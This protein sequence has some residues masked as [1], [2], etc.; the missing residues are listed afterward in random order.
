MSEEQAV[1]L[2]IGN[3]GIATI[4]LN[5]P[6]AFNS[7]NQALL[8]GLLTALL[9]AEG[10]ASVRVVIV[11]GSG[12]AFCGGGDLKAM[13][14]DIDRIESA[15]GFFID[16]ANAAV[17]AMRRL[18][19]PVICSVHG[20]AAGGGFALAAA[21]DFIVAAESA[22]FVIAYSKIAVSPDAGLSYFLTE[23]LG[24]WRAIDALLLRSHLTAA[25]LREAGMVTRVV[26][27][28]QLEAATRQLAQQI[29]QLPPTMANSV[30][31]LVNER[32]DR[33]LGQQM[34]SERQGFIR[35]TGS[36]E[37]AQRVDAFLQK[38]N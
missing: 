27:D 21:G 8:S 32:A 24:P 30:K 29:A 9:K 19:V 10:D 34:S 36:R 7:M 28:D 22:R 11:R 26:A 3:D 18:R 38:K 33:A 17:V 37:F 31:R 2:D 16:T 25:E 5:R 4:T 1:L 6:Q 15:V 23:R 35:C 20:S 13:A 14:D 12:N